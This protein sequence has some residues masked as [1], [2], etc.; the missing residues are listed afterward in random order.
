MARD[1]PIGKAL[2]TELSSRDFYFIVLLTGRPVKTIRSWWWHVS[3]SQVFH[4]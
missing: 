3:T 4:R 1:V 2:Q